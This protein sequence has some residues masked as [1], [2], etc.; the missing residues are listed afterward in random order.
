MGAVEMDCSRGELPEEKLETVMSL[1]DQVYLARERYILRES[2]EAARMQIERERYKTSLLRSISH[3][4]RTPLTGI[5]G[6]TAFLI[7]SLDQLDPD[8]VRDLLTDINT[9]TEWLYSM[10]DNLLNMS[11]I[12]DGRL[13]VNPHGE[14]VDDVISTVVSRVQKRIGKNKFTVN[15]PS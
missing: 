13:K 3:D 10:V 2:R 1:M 11:R 8:T 14:S 12:Q 4:L 5:L 9:D 7:D 15:K 6:G